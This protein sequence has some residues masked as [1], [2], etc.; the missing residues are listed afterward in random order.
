VLD[1]IVASFIPEVQ[2]PRGWSTAG[3]NS[4]EQY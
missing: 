1:T 3:S 4:S 2:P